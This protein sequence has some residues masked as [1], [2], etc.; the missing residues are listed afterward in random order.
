MTLCVGVGASISSVSGQGVI[1][2]RTHVARASHQVKPPM[3]EQSLV[4][5]PIVCLRATVAAPRPSKNAAAVTPATMR[6]LRLVAVASGLPEMSDSRSAA[7]I[8][9]P[10]DDAAAERAAHAAVRCQLWC[11]CCSI[12]RAVA[13]CRRRAS[14]DKLDEA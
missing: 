5:S 3:A 13:L 1:H 11:A 10:R 2:A 8:V 6:L 12:S 14:L 4:S 9:A 7:P